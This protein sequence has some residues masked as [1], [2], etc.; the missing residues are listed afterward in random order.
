LREG[1]KPT[2]AYFARQLKE[3]KREFAQFLS[4]ARG[5]LAEVETQVLIARDLGYLVQDDDI[6]AAVS[7][8]LRSISALM[9][10]LER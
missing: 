8:L 6:L 5:S 1:L 3:S 4:V 9:K 2:I 7:G 10:S